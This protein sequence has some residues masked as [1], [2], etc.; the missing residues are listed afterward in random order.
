M[1]REVH[2][3]EI[4]NLGAPIHFVIRKTKKDISV[5]FKIYRLCKSFKPDIVHCWDGMTAIF[6]I[7]ACKLLGIKLVNSMVTD[8]PIRKNFS[9][10]RWVMAKLSFPFSNSIIGNSRAGLIGYNTPSKKSLCIY[11]GLDLNRFIDIKKPDALF[12]DFLINSK[13]DLF[14]VGMVAAFEPRKDYN[15]LINAAIILTK[16]N[17]NI[18]F[19]LVGDGTEFDQMRKKIPPELNDRIIF[20]GKR[21]DVESIVSLFDVGVLLTNSHVHGEGISNSIIEYMALGKPVIATRGGGTDEVVIDNQNGYLI[22]PNNSDQLVECILK[23]IANKQLALQMGA[24]GLTMVHSKFD[25][26]KMTKCYISVYKD[27]LKI[28]KVK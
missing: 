1:N 25:L 10:K 26:Q 19:I 6:S 15:T 8:S 2:Y 14:I 16:S 5:F 17:K 11:N 3:K 18:R 23:L 21:N 28:N 20:T 13:D 9:N 4:F 24:N 12:R 22:P 7:P 27:L